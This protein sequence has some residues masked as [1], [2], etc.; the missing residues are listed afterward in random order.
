MLQGKCR[1]AIERWLVLIPSPKAGHDGRAGYNV[2]TMSGL[3][4]ITYL[5]SFFLFAI[6]AL[7]LSYG[8][9]LA[10][11][12]Y[13]ESLKELAEGVIGEAAKLKAKRL[14]FLDFAD[15][16]EHAGPVGQFLTEELGTQVLVIG[17]LSVVDHK[18]LAATMRKHHLIRVTAAQASAVRRVAKALRVDLFVTGSF[19]ESAEGLHLT[20]KLVEPRTVQAV[21]AARVT[22]PKAGPLATFFK[23]A[24]APKIEKLESETPKEPALALPG[25]N[26]D[27]Y[28]MTITDIRRRDDQIILDMM[29]EN[30]S[31]RG[32]MI[33]CR[34]QDTY[35]TDEHGTEWRQSVSANREGLCIRGAELSGHEKAHVFLT[36]PLQGKTPGSRLGFHFS[37]MSPRQDAIVMIEGLTLDL[38]EPGTAATSRERAGRAP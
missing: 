5:R 33:H 2:A 30:R 28:S 14:A 7:F 17:D 15:N 3:A 32:L 18:L 29:L 4:M 10:A 37:E 9:V 34:L 6:T 25:H 21:G 36:F 24:P 12:N 16:K 19:V 11:S 1:G 35:L 13:E 20:A 8:P 23:T 26:N 38:Q 31:A 22:L 27:L